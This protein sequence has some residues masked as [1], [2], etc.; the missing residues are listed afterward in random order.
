MRIIIV[1]LFG[2]LLAACSKEPARLHPAAQ[3][4]DFFRAGED[5]LRHIQTL[6][7]GYHRGEKL[8]HIESISYI[9]AKDRSYAF[10]FYRSNRG[11]SNIVLET[12][13]TD[14]GETLVQSFKCEGSSCE[15]KVM[16]VID[17][18]GNVKVNCSCPSCTQVINP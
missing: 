3:R 13:Y 11:L 9:D 14:D 10:V 15:C 8:E 4:A 7:D 1:A 17:D 12:N 18:A 16:T 5:T 2:L 6:L